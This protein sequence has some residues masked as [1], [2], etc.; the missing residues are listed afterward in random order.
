MGCLDAVA[1]GVVLAA[2]SLP[3]AE[4]ASVT[5]SVFG[6]V[7]VLIAWA[8]LRD[9]INKVQWVGILII[10]GSIAYLASG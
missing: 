3:H 4:F 9:P 1:L 10:F 7:T 2:G 5:S 6:L 8:F